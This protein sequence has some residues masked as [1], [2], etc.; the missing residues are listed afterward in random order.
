MTRYTWD[1]LERAARRAEQERRL[2]GRIPRPVFVERVELRPTKE[3]LRDLA[4]YLVEEMRGD[5][6]D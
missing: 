5:E 6:R 3:D 4:R 1:D 2:R